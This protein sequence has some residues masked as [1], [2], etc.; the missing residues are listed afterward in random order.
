MDRALLGFLVVFGTMHVLLIVIPLRDTLKSNISPASKFVWCSFL[1][2]VPFLGAAVFHY[3]FRSGL[4]QG[5]GWEPSA[6]DLGARNPE[7]PGRHN[8]KNDGH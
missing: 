4:F 5:K 2:L 6:H 8:P 3:R 1:L 7:L